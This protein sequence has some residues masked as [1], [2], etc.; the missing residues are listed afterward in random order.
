MNTDFD[1]RYLDYLSH[2]NLYCSLTDDE[3]NIFNQ[4]LPNY[5]ILNNDTR[6][7]ILTNGNGGIEFIIAKKSDGLF[8]IIIT[9]RNIAITHDNGYNVSL[10]TIINT[11]KSI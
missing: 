5:V 1:T 2:L 10:E 7:I 4:Q 11:I 9:S 6:L 8:T 3:I